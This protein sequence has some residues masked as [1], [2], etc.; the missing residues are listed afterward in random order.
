MKNSAEEKHPGKRLALFFDGTWNVQ[1]DNTNVWRLSLMLA[2]RGLDGVPQRQF[3]DSGVGTAWYDRISGG[4]FGSGLS[5]NVRSA[6]RW[7]M[8]NYDDGDEIFLFGFSRGAFTARSLAGLIA[9][10]GILS[11]DAPLSFLQVYERYQQGRT[12]PPIFELIR[13]KD[14]QKRLSFEERVLLEYARYR[15]HLIKMVGVWDTVG[16]LGIPFGNIKM[17]SRKTLQF[18][19]TRLSTVVEN[20][21]HALAIDEFRKPYEAILWTNF[22]PEK[23]VESVQPDRR[24]IEQRWFPGAHANIGGGYRSDLLAQ[25]PLS[26]IQNN[27]G[28]HGLNFRSTVRLSDE[29]LDF[30]PTDSYSQFLNG[31]WKLI[32]AGNRFYRK[33]MADPIMKQARQDS[34]D[35]TT[36]W[37]HTVNERIDESVFNR[38]LK[39]RDGYCP[40]PLKEW[41]RRKSLNLTSILED[42]SQFSGTVA[43]PGIELPTLA[44][45]K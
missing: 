30:Q 43:T 34:V 15:R 35:P 18:H 14:E 29:D 8:E 16:S 38:C 26:W 25:R 24:M 36:G 42:H 33:L 3:Y 21:Y 7:L 1:G 5:E 39:S 11:P 17:V 45:R 2:E 28:K 12:V 20:S 44:G 37:V 4:A 6:Y 32:T 9:R 19:N 40:E 27:A 31:T 13:R 23:R 10:C 41:A 22:L